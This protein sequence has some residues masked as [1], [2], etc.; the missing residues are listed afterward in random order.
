MWFK[1]TLLAVM[2]DE[3]LE[4]VLVFVS[5]SPSVAKLK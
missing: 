2:H 3:A 4:L 5:S 1:T